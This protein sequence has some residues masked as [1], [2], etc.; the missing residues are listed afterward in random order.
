MYTTKTQDTSKA[1]NL[2]LEHSCHLALDL[3]GLLAMRLGGKQKAQ[4]STYKA[5][6]KAIQ[7]LTS[8]KVIT[9]YKHVQQKK[10]WEADLEQIQKIQAQYKETQEALQALENS[11]HLKTLNILNT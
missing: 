7:T 3:M 2:V 5:F 4:N 1:H 8:T 11:G 9:Q 10:K 6:D